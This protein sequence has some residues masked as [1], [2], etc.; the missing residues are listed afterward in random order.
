MGVIFPIDK[1]Y[2]VGDWLASFFWGVFTVLFLICVVTSLRNI[3]QRWFSLGTVTVMYCLATSHIAI[4]LTR[5]IQAFVVHVHDSDEGA[6]LY[7]ANIA[8]D[9]NRSKDMIYIT[10]IW[11]GDSILVWRCFVVWNRD[12]RVIALPCIMVIA[13]AVSGYGAVGMYFDPNLNP[14]VATNWASGMLAVS[15]VTNFILTILTAG[16][17]WFLSRK[18]DFDAQ[19]EPTSYLPHR[20]VVLAIL[21]AGLLVTIAKFLEF[22]FFELAPINGLT[23]NNALYVMMECMPQL[24]GIAPTLIILAVNLGFTSSGPEAY[25]VMGS[26]WNSQAATQFIQ[27]LEKRPGT[28]QTSGASSDISSK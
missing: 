23:G 26:T 11:L 17:L 21:E 18:I 9:I 8:I 13:T 12:W 24:M 6:I 7:L 15:M 14:I 1:A 19:M 28:A 10:A 3:R 16:R 20:I 22:L 4:A 25:S 5:L 27:D 2:I